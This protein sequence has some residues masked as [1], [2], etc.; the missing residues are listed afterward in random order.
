[1]KSFG[2]SARECEIEFA[3]YGL[4]AALLCDCP[5]RLSHPM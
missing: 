1:M 3:L 5:A 4:V 2:S